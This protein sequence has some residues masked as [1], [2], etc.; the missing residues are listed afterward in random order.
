MTMNRCLCQDHEDGLKPD[1]GHYYGCPR[2]QT[3]PGQPA[4]VEVGRSVVI[5]DGQGEPSCWPK[6]REDGLRL[7][8]PGII[9]DG[10]KLLEVVTYEWPVY[11]QNDRG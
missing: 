6:D 9:R 3:A 5:V 8:S 7:M 2:C 1:G 11:D 4:G 10:W